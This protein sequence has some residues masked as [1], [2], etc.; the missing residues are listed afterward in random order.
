MKYQAKVWGT[1]LVLLVYVFITSRA[2][3]LDRGGP[4]IIFWMIGM[5]A[6]LFGW[7]VIDELLIANK[8]YLPQFA[9]KIEEL[10]AEGV[11]IKDDVVRELCEQGL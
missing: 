8:Q 10:E 9:N 7:R 3:V 11:T 5:L 4:A 2:G 6:V 1:V